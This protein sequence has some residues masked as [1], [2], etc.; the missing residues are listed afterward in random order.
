MLEKTITDNSTL[1]LKSAAVKLTLP[2]IEIT[3]L[4]AQ[5]TNLNAEIKRRLLSVVTEIIDKQLT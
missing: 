5:E 2:V 1:G 3:C 4:Q